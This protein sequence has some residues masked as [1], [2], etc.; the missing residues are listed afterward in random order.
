MNANP[1]QRAALLRALQVRKIHVRKHALARVPPRIARAFAHPWAPVSALIRYFGLFPDPLLSFWLD[2]PVGHVV[3]TEG[4]GGYVPGE[5]SVGKRHLAAV[6]FI[7]LASLV[8]EGE[9]PL[10]Y[11]AHLLDHLLGCD[12]V[13]EG[14]WLSEGGGY[15]PAWKEV[16]ARLKKQFTLGYANSEAAREDPRRYFAEG[17]VAYWTD[18]RGLRVQD[19][20]LESILRTTLFDPAFWR[21]VYR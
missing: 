11:I 12:G 1:E 18:R 20:G 17:L 21:R 14:V 3:L 10:L 7:P 2:H 4:E 8:G 5:V 13:P 19:P 16:G 9:H 15:L 6:A